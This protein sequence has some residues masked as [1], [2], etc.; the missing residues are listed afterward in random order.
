MT[1]T[2]TND[3]RLAEG[4]GATFIRT[5]S[6]KWWAKDRGGFMVVRGVRSRAEAAR[7][8]CED[9]DLT[10]TTPEAILARIRHEYRPYDTLPEF[11]EGF[12]AYQLDRA[13]RHNPHTGY[14]G[15]AFDRGTN[16]AMLY[17][18]AMAHLA[19]H[20]EEVERAGP[21][22]LTRLLRAGRC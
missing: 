12:R 10:P 16:A 6:G 1:D 13:H 20:P 15:Q 11:E 14:K 8:Y 3:E 2:R 22:W 9:K 19:G 18:R 21:G 17:A 4:D 7:L 5:A